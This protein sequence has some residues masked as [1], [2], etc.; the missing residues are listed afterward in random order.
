MNQNI[1]GGLLTAPSQDFSQVR[2]GRR[3]RLMFFDVDLSVA[4]TLD[5][6]SALII[7]ISGNFFY[8]DQDP[9]FSGFAS[10]GF[11]DTNSDSTPVYVGP[12]SLSRVPYTRIKVS[13]LAQSGKKL[14]ILYGTDI[15]FTPSMAP[16]QNVAI[17]GGTNIKS[18]SVSTLYA[19]AVGAATSP[20]LTVLGN[21]IEIVR[22][23]LTIY[24][25]AVNTDTPGFIL[26]PSGAQLIYVRAV[27]IV[28]NMPYTY[29]ENYAQPIFIPA[30][31]V[32]SA[33]CGHNTGSVMGHITYKQL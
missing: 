18:I 7:P 22:A 10:V 19:T 23:G 27:P 17:T 11:E 3:S 24:N 33:A 30:G 6:T 31:G 1:Y 5:D 15:D 13:N 29:F 8:V 12:G 26:T 28:A 32:V 20:I 21:G 16:I 4:R 2:D 25:S 14:R 9:S